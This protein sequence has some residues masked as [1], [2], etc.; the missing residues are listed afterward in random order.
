MVTCHKVLVKD[1]IWHA[2]CLLQRLLWGNKEYKYSGL[3]YCSWV[4]RR[5]ERKKEKRQLQG[6][7]VLIQ[8]MFKVTSVIPQNHFSLHHVFN[9]SKNKVWSMTLQIAEFPYWW[10]SLLVF[11]YLFIFWWNLFTGWKENESENSIWGEGFEITSPPSF[12]G[13]RNTF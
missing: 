4:H 11:I 2:S 7:T 13:Q 12:P 10:K 5:N 3:F 9:V 1:K 8:D 6:F